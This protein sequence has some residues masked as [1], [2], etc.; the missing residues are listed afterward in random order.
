V[1]KDRGAARGQGAEASGLHFFGVE[2]PAAPRTRQLVDAGGLE[3]PLDVL[4]Q[5]HGADRAEEF[6]VPTSLASAIFR[7]L[8]RSSTR[9]ISGQASVTGSSGALLSE[10]FRLLRIRIEN[11]CNIAVPRHL[12]SRAGCRSQG[13]GVR[14]R[15]RFASFGPGRLPP[16]RWI[17][18]A[19]RPVPASTWRIMQTCR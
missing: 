1:P 14:R 10:N 9:S 16:L 11:S 17:L 5:H 4:E 7:R 12:R 13:R 8:S 3:P 2:G 15:V 19:A 6:R 18:G